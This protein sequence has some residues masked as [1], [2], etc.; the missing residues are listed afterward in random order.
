MSPLSLCSSIFIRSTIISYNCLLHYNFWTAA[1]TH[2]SMLFLKAWV[3][4]L[5]AQIYGVD[6]IMLLKKSTDWTI[7]IFEFRIYFL[8][9]SINSEK[10]L[11]LSIL[12]KMPAIINFL[13]SA[14]NWS[15]WSWK[16]EWYAN[17][18]SDLLLNT[19]PCIMEVYLKMVFWNSCEFLLFRAL[20][21]ITWNWFFEIILTSN[22]S[23]F[24]FIGFRSYVCLHYTMFLS[25][26]SCTWSWL[27]CSSSTSNSSN[28]Y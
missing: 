8:Q 27:N 22:C 2:A 7:W 11:D 14:S 28:N 9:R 10:I 25:P 17:T 5:K 20:G 18:Y 23:F 15:M 24:S 1:Y 21:K 19:V 6:S 26:E 13:K 3:K 16:C 4:L 12:S